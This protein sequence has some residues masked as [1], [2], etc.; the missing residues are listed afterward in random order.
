MP[1]VDHLALCHVRDS[2]DTVTLFLTG[3]VSAACTILVRH[4]SDSLALRGPQVF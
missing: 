1:S 2:A 3:I 4:S